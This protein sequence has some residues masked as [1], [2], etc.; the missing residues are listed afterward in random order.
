M[1]SLDEYQEMVM[2]RNPRGG[3]PV[4]AGNTV[5]QAKDTQDISEIREDVQRRLMLGYCTCGKKIVVGYNRAEHLM[6]AMQKRG[7][8]PARRDPVRLR[9]AKL[10]V[11]GLAT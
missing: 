2:S 6:S 3:R 5:W 8:E 9:I 1:D 7:I 4:Q 11:S 10:L